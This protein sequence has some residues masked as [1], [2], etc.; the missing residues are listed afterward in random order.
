MSIELKKKNSI[1]SF[2]LIL[3]Y[4]IYYYNVVFVMKSIGMSL[5]KKILL[6]KYYTFYLSLGLSVFG[7]IL[8]N[9]KLSR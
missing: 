5:W 4:K 2:I 7:P 9:N 3:I 6:I 8:Y 1:L